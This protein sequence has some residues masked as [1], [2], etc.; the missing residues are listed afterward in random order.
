[1]QFKRNGRLK[2]ACVG[3]CPVLSEVLESRVLLSSVVP[4]GWTDSD[5]GA[6][7]KA[8]SATV[9]FST[10]VWTVAGNGIDIYNKSDQ[11]N[12]ASENFS[13]DGTLI[14]KVTSVTNTNVWAKSGLMFR[15]STAAGA[16]FADLVITPKSG[17]SFEWRTTTN[18]SATQVQVT[19][20]VAPQWLE[21]KRSGN[22]F[23]GFY[24]S[25]GITWKQIGTTETVA[26]PTGA[27]A[28]L[29]VT[30]ISGSAINTVTFSNVSFSNTGP[31]FATAAAAT[32]NPT[33]GLTS[34]LSAAGSDSAGAG[35]LIY[36]W[37]TVGTEPGTV[38][39]S[40]NQSN[41]AGNTIAT[42]SKAGV[43]SLQ[44]T[45][46][47]PSGLSATGFV[48]VTVTAPSAGGLPT[49]WSNANINSPKIAGTAAY[50]G[51]A[52]T[53]SGGGATIGGTADQFD[54]ASKSFIGD[55]ILIA[56]VASLGDTNAAADAGVMFRASTA[57][58]ALFA[59]VVVTPSDGVV[60]GWRTS[61]NATASTTT[62]T[63][64]ATPRWVELIR[65]ANKF[66]AYYSSDGL[67]W[68]QIGAAETVAMSGAALAGLAVTAHDNTKQTTAAFTNVSIAANSAP[69]IATAAAAN[70][71]PAVNLKT[72][73][74]ALGADDGGEANLTYTWSVVGTAPGT[75]TFSANGTNAAKSST[76]TL[77]KAGT[78]TLQVKIA[79]TGGLSATSTVVV[80]TAGV[81]ATPLG[82][83]AVWNGAAVGVSWLSTAGANTYDVYRSTTPG[84]EGATPIATGIT[85]TNY[86]DIAVTAGQQ[87]YYQI[88]GV[89]STGGAQGVRS[90]E[91]ASLASLPTT[92]IISEFMAA[93]SKT[94]ADSGGQYGDWLELYNPT[95]STVSLSGYYLS[96]KLSDPTLWKIPAVTI[97]GDGF[98]VIFCDGTN[99]TNPANQLHTNF[100]LSSSGESVSLVA[101]NGT[102]VL[103]SYTFPA[104][105]SDISYG[106]AMAQTTSGGK[107]ITSYGA[108]GYL[109]PTP[110]T[111]NGSLLGSAIVDQPTF[112]HKDGFYTSSFQLKMSDDVAGAKIRYTLDGSAPTATTG[113]LYTGPITISGETIIRAVAYAPNELTSAVS[114]VTYIYT[115]QVITQ[116][117]N[118]KAPTGWPTSWGI[119]TVHY[120]MD[121]RVVTNPAYSGE[122][123]Q[124]LL[125][126]PTFS[127]TMNLNDLF[128]PTTGIYS[129]SENDGSAWVRPASIE[130]INPSGGPAGFQANIGLA[131]KGNYSSRH[132]DAKHGFRVEF[133]SG[134]GAS[135]LDYPLFGANAAQS[136]QE[137]DLRTD[138]NNSW[139]FGDPASYIGVRD[140]FNNLTLAAEGQAAMHSQICFLYIN[141]QFWGLYDA[142]ERPDDNFAASYFGGSATNYDVIKA[143]D[144]YTTVADDGNLN[145]W[146][147]LYTDVTTLDMSTNA[148][149]EMI[150]GNNANGTPNPAYKDLLD[151]NS[152]VQFMLL[153]YY[154][155]NL[156]SPFSSFTTTDSPNNFYAIRPQDG[157]FGFRF[158]ATDSEWTLL[159]VNA[160]RVNANTV[161]PSL[162]LSNPAV[163]FQ[164]LEANADFKQ[165]V[166]DDV[167]KDFFNNGPMTATV[168]LANF[169]SLV[170]QVQGPVVAESA[171]WGDTLRASQPYTRNVEWQAEINR[172]E[173]SYFPQR[174][175]IV[176]TQL[177]NAKLFP[178][179]SAPT[180][181]QN[182]GAISTGF[183][184]KI[185]NPATSG[186]IYY[187]LDGSDPRTITGAL[188][189][190][191]LL[192]VGPIT[193]DGTT[194]VKSGILNGTTWSPILD[195]TFATQ[196]TNVRITELDYDPST[197][198]AGAVDADNE[199][200]EFIELKNFGSQ[201]VDLD[202]VTFTNG[203]TYTFGKVT[204][205]PGQVGVLVHNQAAFQARYGTGVNILGSY[206]TSG[207]SFSNSG[208]EITLVD[209]SG[210]VL[211]DFTYSPT[212]YPATKGGGSSLD[213]IKPS[214]SPNLNNAASWQ[215]SAIVDGTP[216]V[217]DTTPTAAPTGL[218]TTAGAE[219]IAL[220]WNAVVGASG[221]DVYRATGAGGEGSVPFKTG[222]SSPAF[223]D[224]GLT[225]GKTYYYTVTAVDFGGQSPASAEV[226]TAPI[227]PLVAPPTYSRNGGVI[228]A[229][230]QLTI[231]DPSMSGTIYY[232]L[233][234][235]DPETIGGTAV[236]YAGAI[237]LQAGATEVKSRILSGSTWSP[238]VDYTFGTQ[239]T[240]VRVTEL[241][242]DPSNPPA[243]SAYTVDDYEFVELQNFGSQPV[244]L[245]DVAFTKGISYTFGDL[246]LAPGQVGVL[247]HNLTAFQSRYGTGTGIDILGSYQT[248]GGSFS[249]SGEEVT[250][251]DASGQ[252]LEDFTYSPT[253]YPTTAGKG[254]S[255]DVINPSSFPDLNNSANWRPSALVDGTP[256]VDDTVPTAAPAGLVATP[257]P[258]QIGLTWNA[259]PGAATYNVYRGLASGG[260]ATTPIATG[261][262]S[263]AYTDKS[264]VDGQS[265]YYTVTAVDFGGESPASDEMNTAPVAPL[266]P[267]P[268]YSQNGGAIAAGFQLTITNP[269]DPDGTIYYTLDGS[270]PDGSM[271]AVPYGGPIALGAGATE[272]KSQI[273]NGV[274]WSPVV[275]YTFGTQAT[276]VRVTELS[277]DPSSDITGTYN[278]DD[279]EFIELKNF[280][281]Q[282][283]DL[284]D[285][286]FTKGIAYTFG[287]VTLAPGQVGVLVHNTAAF[288][289]RYGTGINIIGDYLSTGQSFSNS[290]EEVTLV[291]ASGQ[292]LDDF[293]Y[294]PTWYSTTA[295]KG[296]SLDVVDPSSFPDLN[297]SANWRASAVANGTPGADDTVPT[298][299]PTGL[300]AISGPEQV[301][302][303]WN[304]VPGAAAYNIYR[305]TTA[306]AEGMAPYLAGQA[307]ST[308]TDSGLTDGK[309]YYYTVTA[310][311]FGGESPATGEMSAT[312]A[313][314]TVAAPT[315]S[316]NG[317][318]IAPG[319]KLTMTN[320]GGAGKIY[321]TLDGSDP[322][323][324]NG[325]P[326]GTAAMY[327]GAITLQTTT[328]VKSRVLNGITWS[329]ALDY[330]F[331][332]PATNVRV[333]ELN[334]D[335]AT[336]PAGAADSSNDDYEFI[337]L[338][339]FGT[340]PVNLSGVAFTKGI[341]YTFGAVTLAPGQVGVL[342]H[343]TA[344]FVARYGTGINIIGDYLSTGESFSNSGEE[345]T[346]IDAT[347]QTLED[348]TYSPTWYATTK[349]KGPSL[350]VINPATFPTLNNST[351]WRA[352]AVVNGTPG[353]D[354]TIPTAAPTNVMA[355]AGA[356]QISLTWDP[357]P[358]AASY[359]VYRSTAAAGEGSVPFATGLTSPAFMDT[360]LMDGQ[361]YYYTITAVDFGGE[362]VAS[363]Q[364]SAMPTGP[365]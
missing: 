225:D 36:S 62:V 160:N 88:T 1:V 59:D 179:V 268:V 317:G 180:F 221:Y 105:L 11:F 83:T 265:Y 255:L 148:N 17:V 315:Y 98:L 238:V 161:K 355:K 12:F 121:P 222:L 295:G 261:L 67:T 345:V 153:S 252:V 4:A 365:V 336:P 260:E 259:V 273:L 3:V 157:S 147:Q 145:A 193:L 204:L 93:N 338:K 186:K 236:P 229:G 324:M 134:Y 164:K 330:T 171:R 34:D 197:P 27:L 194:E 305:A 172:L 42:F 141:G 176:L 50:S 125:E 78:Y 159:D 206:Q 200:Y 310:V 16:Q 52:W 258:E 133:S 279:F 55:G 269:A 14:A 271:T 226:H 173:T 138:Q 320:P 75:V 185:T 253:W 104:Q 174:T 360:G 102:T 327:A 68:K 302:L 332:A 90:F 169:K 346:L 24:S 290:G 363:A 166:A 352:S 234:G 216:G 151:V 262:T 237:T 298:A 146:S 58:G 201:P 126:L 339:N 51:G 322:E 297:T 73:L 349:G 21:L 205:A 306:G 127:I 359:N 32:P 85:T 319:F 95:S 304:P 158:V 331:S 175:G 223:T 211:D 215:P 109:N 294:S 300:S 353:V 184:L 15:A 43:Y 140:E 71:N 286:A 350:D 289:S 10:G 63:G 282:P 53:V 97:A 87:Y 111:V 292:V 354:D 81:I 199:D 208:E 168:A 101:P 39:F 110:R 22:A 94:L 108:T 44:V 334:Y 307:A 247:V 76:A 80:S 144:T 6:P 195:Y 233:D 28:G 165:L 312:P 328:E 214:S 29:A 248:G 284:N 150:Q 152:L 356:E 188:S 309:A 347:G 245:N 244:D 296:P 47:D 37:A 210:Q 26:M 60:F 18:G 270:D 182:G 207:N 313:A 156:D 162:S 33:T 143:S 9:N 196:A 329:P 362:S 249:N 132:A 281:A 92:P 277:Y 181:N 25:D 209:A 314:P 224:T 287:D 242:Y 91:A 190:S 217:D 45:V 187:T 189:A 123:Q 272:V 219:Q 263:P 213:V 218:K 274:T 283:V 48:S 114:A 293:T 337:E 139:N 178:S 7:A 49:G 228:S 66:Y 128:S 202:D 288:Q 57:A 212:W 183:Q 361:T 267:A 72:Q 40:A 239:A 149:Y 122:I 112:D 46:I 77:S 246:T 79:D 116:S 119:S 311:D 84:G 30:A 303:T 364:V 232:T 56:D 5:I 342:V 61:T 278:N 326:S 254:P 321:Y 243:G 343:S 89:A 129:N 31:T 70:A 344:A 325:S 240:N 333:T 230:Y 351:D 120:G 154:T 231:S 41:A 241:D 130:L 107:V 8:G 191:A 177:K 65:A 137:F 357:V 264:L 318:T 275:D 250:L 341:K 192:Y 308:F 220:T 74:S 299:A 35:K 82:V 203:I 99:L 251:M 348:F 23:T 54:L 167:E 198:P 280:G 118:G 316:Q 20:I 124:D 163:F 69:T 38:A 291:D 301:M 136:F 106:I 266:V 96:D 19:G 285:V 100:S 142:V 103:S 2:A 64:I 256:G 155:G 323:A 135:E 227:A 113:T 335:P 13:G 358:G 86:T 257:G 340:L 276:N 170:S 131:I 117:S 115:S 235:S